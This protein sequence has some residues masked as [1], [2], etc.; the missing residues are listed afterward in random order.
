MTIN[1]ATNKNNNRKDIESDLL[2]A[3]LQKHAQSATAAAEQMAGCSG[4]KCKTAACLSSLSFSHLTSEKGAY[5]NQGPSYRP[6]R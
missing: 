1:A 5:D 3:R 4:R 2:D 6:P